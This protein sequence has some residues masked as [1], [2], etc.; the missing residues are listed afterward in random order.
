MFDAKFM[1][2]M[3]LYGALGFELAATIVG[4]LLAGYYL[5][6]HFDKSPAFLLVGLFFGLGLGGW[7][8][9]QTLRLLA[10]DKDLQ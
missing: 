4:S 10:N 9:M 1:K 8:M 7:R 2:A 6:K 5:D 3:A